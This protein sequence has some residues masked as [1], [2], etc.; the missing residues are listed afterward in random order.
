MNTE[1]IVTLVG[2]SVAITSG[3]YGF[4]AGKKNGEL[5]C[6]IDSGR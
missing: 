4:M 6:V 1:T 3:I 2:V 5:K